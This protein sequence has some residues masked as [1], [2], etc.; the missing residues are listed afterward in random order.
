M[1]N[2][3]NSH[4]YSFFLASYQECHASLRMKLPPGGRLGWDIPPDGPSAAQC[5]A[6]K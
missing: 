2:I 3:L 5:H 4:L 6:N 1:Y